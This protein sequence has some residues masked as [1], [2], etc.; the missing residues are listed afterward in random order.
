[1][2]RQRATAHSTRDVISVSTSRSRDVVFKRLGLGL[3]E[4]WEGLGLDLVSDWKSNVS[5][6]VSVSNY[7][8]SFTS[9][10]RNRMQ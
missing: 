7:R 4:T 6:L 8:V 10:D 3:V 1:M 5:G 9:Q 2:D